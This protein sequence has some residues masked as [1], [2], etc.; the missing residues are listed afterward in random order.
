MN[1]LLLTLLIAPHNELSELPSI[2]SIAAT[3]GEYIV[4]RKT[5]V[6]TTNVYREPIDTAESNG[7]NEAILEIW[8]SP[9]QSAFVF[10]RNSYNNSI[11]RPGYDMKLIA[12]N[13]GSR[14]RTTRWAQTELP[15]L[16]E[17]QANDFVRWVSDSQ[18]HTYVALESKIHAITESIDPSKAEANSSKRTYYKQWGDFFD[19]MG[20]N[21]K[22]TYHRSVG[23]DSS[24]TLSSGQVLALVDAEKGVNVLLGRKMLLSLP[25]GT[26]IRE[27]RESSDQ[28]LTLTTYRLVVPGSKST[29]SNTTT[30]NYRFASYLVDLRNNIV[31]YQ[32]DAYLM[33]VVDGNLTKVAEKLGSDV[34]TMV[35]DAE[36]SLSVHRYWMDQM[37][38]ETRTTYLRW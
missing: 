30:G 16:E 3:N 1:A 29:P 35:Y 2:W 23:A 15:E 8:P 37:I 9:S 33:R 4:I 12:Y 14:M 18:Y 13:I 36:N 7:P 5:Q 38:G 31:V 21:R 10:L 26:G 34:T 11:A 6:S 24:L 22:W 28:W 19:K 25:K 32:N 17:I 27:L 20:P